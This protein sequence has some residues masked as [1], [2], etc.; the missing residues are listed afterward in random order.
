MIE[1]ESTPQGQPAIE[2][3]ETEGSVPKDWTFMVYLS[4]DNNLSVEMGYAIEQMRRV[5]AS[6]EQI[7]LLVYF[8]GYSADIRRYMRI[9]QI[10]MMHS[11]FIAR[12]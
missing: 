8:D 10:N 7:N 1:T 9:S 3:T 5:T 6:N 11:N 4:G 2:A 12:T